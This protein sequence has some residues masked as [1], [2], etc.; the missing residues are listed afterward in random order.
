M[1]EKRGPQ[2]VA[3]EKGP[4]KNLVSWI[5]K[6]QQ[7]AHGLVFWKTHAIE[8]FSLKKKLLSTHSRIFDFLRN[9]HFKDF[10]NGKT[11]QW[12]GL[13]LFGQSF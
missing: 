7:W 2:N 4:A 1:N 3:Q 13:N 10:H 9:D 12:H 8:E 6:I 5:D 11:C